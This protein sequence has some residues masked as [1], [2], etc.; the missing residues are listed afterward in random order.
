METSAFT[1]MSNLTCESFANAC[2]VLEN[3]IFPAFEDAVYADDTTWVL[4]ACFVILTMQSG[5]GL[6]E[7][8][9]SSPG[10]EVNVMLKNVSD[11][12]FGVL[13]FYFLGYGIAYGHPSNPFMG[14][15]DFVP[16]ENF[17]DPVA[18]GVLFAKY[19]FQL[20]F[21]ATS[22]TIVSGG[23]AMRMKFRVYCIFSFYA[24]TVY[25]FVAHWV[26]AE[27]GWLNTLGAHDF[28]G[29]GPVHLLGGCNALV[30]I[31]FVG[32][33]RGRFDNSRPASDFAESSP[34]GQLFGLLILWFAWIGFN[35]GSSFGI[36]QEKWLVATRAG[37]NT[38]NASAGGGITGLLYSQWAT[39]GT[40]VR[41]FDMVNGILGALVASSPTCA[42]THTYDAL[43]IGSV[44]S[45]L[46]CWSNEFIFRK[47]LHMD[48]PVGAVGAHGV[49]GVWGLIA[50]G[51]FADSRFP[52]VDVIN[53]LFRGGGFTLLG[54]QLVE[55]LSII[56]WSWVAMAPFFY[57][58]GVAFGGDWKSPRK[59]L[60]LS[61][62]TQGSNPH[63]ADP[64]IHG[65]LEDN[66][67]VEEVLNK[68]KA[69]FFRE[70]RDDVMKKL[71]HTIDVEFENTIRTTLEKERKTLHESLGD[72]AF[73]HKAAL[74]LETG[75]K[76]KEATGHQTGDGEEDSRAEG[77]E[78]PSQLVPISSP[79]QTKGK[80][81][82]RDSA[83]RAIS[84]L[85]SGGD[86]AA[87]IM[88]LKPKKNSFGAT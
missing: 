74:A 10:N 34:T 18:S 12:L 16:T 87:G 81:E 78:N 67:N 61:F 30:A 9:V 13:A 26:W 84:Q 73:S 19:L 42:A 39:K 27:D 51:L 56:A 41:P 70:I 4:T 7:I 36:T 25:S 44:G 40:Y 29:G 52:G 2:P 77:E 76:M 23:I 6:L 57:I 88:G 1:T 75:E 45:F 65:C 62:P 22:T 33:R 79:Q 55:A 48:D 32:P 46:A 20:S 8:G 31:W 60:R 35:C 72:L 64:R 50:V 82:R 69:A 24:V 43:I 86:T 54:Y 66:I 37:V 71:R 28:A 11:V 21:A 3:V 47:Y 38:M 59:G 63:Q 83:L 53:G 68:I 80:L 17:D 85:F 5:F 58:L 49:A 15:G 14:L